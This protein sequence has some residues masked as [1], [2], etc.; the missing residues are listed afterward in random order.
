[1][2]RSVALILMIVL[3]FNMTS[4]TFMFDMIEQ[5]YLNMSAAELAELSDSK[6]C[7]VLWFRTDYKVESFEDSLAGFESLN[8]YEKVLYTV[9][10]FDMEYLNGG[11]C[12]F[13]VNSSRVVAPYVSEALRTIGADKHAEMYDSFISDNR[14]D[15]TD[16]SEFDTDSIDKYSV[17]SQKY[18]FDDFDDAF[19]KLGLLRPYLEEYIKRKLKRI[20]KIN[21]RQLL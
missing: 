20:Y 17:L 7:E 16:L 6:L 5:N 9:E 8:H 15:L 18:P 14:I 12:Q 4:C 13:F 3:M 2:K 19:I 11:L 1:M 21:R 10:Y